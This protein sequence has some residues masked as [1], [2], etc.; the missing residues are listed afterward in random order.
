[1]SRLT[2]EKCMFLR[3]SAFTLIYFS[4][5]SQ[6]I[7]VWWCETNRASSFVRNTSNTGHWFLFISH[8]L[9]TSVANGYSFMVVNCQ[10][11][12]FT[13]Y[14]LSAA[15]MCFSLSFWCVEMIRAHVILHWHYFPQTQHLDVFY[16]G[17]PFSA[18]YLVDLLVLFC[19]LQRLTCISCFSVLAHC[20]WFIWGV[21][22]SHHKGLNHITTMWWINIPF[23]SSQ[24]QAEF[25]MG[26]LFNLTSI[27]KMLLYE[28]SSKRVYFTPDNGHRRSFC[29]LIN[30]VTD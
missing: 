11:P 30:K 27:Q 29:F 20:E 25:C 19:F 7:S 18:G 16:C 13:F 8:P 6:I 24:K 1:M 28:L 2:K 10:W 9:C 3:R 15:L 4:F 12:G 26:N 22:V 21:A 14:K 5:S 23:P 17:C